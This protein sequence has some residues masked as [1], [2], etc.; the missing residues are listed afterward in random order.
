[1]EEEWQKMERQRVLKQRLALEEQQASEESLATL[2]PNSY[3]PTIEGAL[4]IPKPYGAMA[5]VKPPIES[6]N[7]RHIRKPAANPNQALGLTA[8][9]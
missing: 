4:P 5:P 1:M 3:M 9:F 7:M 6:G 2:R 8:S